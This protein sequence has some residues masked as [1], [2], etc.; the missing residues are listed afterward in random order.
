MNLE[1]NFQ[2][3]QEGE[4]TSTPHVD[5]HLTGVPSSIVNHVHIITGNFHD[6]Q[7]DLMVPGAYPIEIQRNYASS[8]V[9]N[10]WFD[11]YRTLTNGW[12]F[13]QNNALKFTYE[14][15]FE[16]RRHYHFRYEVGV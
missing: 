6:G 15:I 16:K 10:H 14:T 1:N 7:I 9:P 11:E 3:H 13:D 5:A 12:G 2:I 4:E 8:Y